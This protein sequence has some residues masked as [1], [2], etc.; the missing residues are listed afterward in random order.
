MVDLH[1]MDK[2]TSQAEPYELNMKAPL[3]SGHGEIG[4][5]ISLQ[6]LA[7]RGA[8][9]F[10][11][12]KQVENNTI[13]FENNL[14]DQI[15][16]GDGFSAQIKGG[17]DQF[18]AMTGM[19]AAAAE[20]DE[21][22]QPADLSYFENSPTNLDLQANNINTIIWTT[23]YTG[24]FSWIKLPVLNEW[25]RPIHNDGISPVKHLYFNGLPWL[26]NLKSSLVLGSI[27]D[28]EA[29]SSYVLKNHHENVIAMA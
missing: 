23:G 21:A 1:F 4:H 19:Q 18:I 13:V 29:V 10:G 2:P 16:F 11:H 28:A 17:I 14:I 27:G 12:L 7:K 3:M 8:K 24:D 9:L 5:T 20:A 15:Q 26:R 6:A 25:G 22:D